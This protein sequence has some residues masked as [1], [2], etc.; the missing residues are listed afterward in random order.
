MNAN[1]TST[2]SREEL[3]REFGASGYTFFN[4][5]IEA[6]EFNSKL[7]GTDGAA[8]YD[9]MRRTDGQ[10]R[11]TLLVQ[12]L[13]IHAATWTVEAESD[14]IERDLNE[15]LFER[16]DFDEYLR[17]YLTVLDFG[18]S[19]LEK[20][21]M[22]DA[23]RLWFRKLAFRAQTSIVKWIV[24]DQTG[25]LKEIVQ[26]VSKDN[27]TRDVTIPAEKLLKITIQQEGN[28]FEGISILRSAYKHW[29]IKDQVERIDAIAQE[30]W[31]LGIPYAQGPEGG[32]DEKDERNAINTLKNL[33]SGAKAWMFFPY[34]WDF[35]VKG[36]GQGSRYDPMP[37]IKYHDELIS[38]NALAMFLNLGTTETGSRALG[39][40]FSDMFFNAEK[41]IANGIVGATNKQVIR[42]FLRVNYAN[43]DKIKATLRWSDLQIRSLETLARATSLFAAAGFMTPDRETEN[44]IRDMADLPSKDLTEDSGETG[45]ESFRERRRRNRVRRLAEPVFWR[46]LTEV[47]KSMSLR[48]IDGRQDD[49]EDQVADLFVKIRPVWVDSLIE[50]IREALSDGDASDVDQVSIPVPLRNQM[51]AGIVAIERELFRFGRQKVQEEQTRQLRQ[52]GADEALQAA[53]AR[54]FRDEPPES[55]EI[56]DVFWVRARRYLNRLSSRVE[57]VAI[58]RALDLH[59]TKGTDIDPEDLDTLSDDLNGMWMNTARLEAKAVISSAFNMGRTHQAEIQKEEI[60]FAEYSAILDENLCE[61]CEDLDG[62]RFD[63]GSEEYY[64]NAPPNKQ[65]LSAQSGSNRCRCVYAFAFK[66]EQRSRG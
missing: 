28:N 9:K 21:W 38:R 23:S 13:P 12:K 7:T 37:T 4:G 43:G 58:E 60:E 52:A 27:F 57:N 56:T 44:I 14:A 65:C 34:G 18:F 53:E 22:V 19:L 33:K 8:T 55:K 46:E 32:Y 26:R 54:S 64:A 11:A 50:Q 3:V 6:G 51:A 35:G 15:M 59:R 29:F 48:E 47:E 66:T 25:D 41:A 17:H 39:G 1:D 30:R 36:P 20:V 63:V 45:G 62:E 40:T 2:L 61:E 24:D 49:A 42:P 10:V 5:L 31:G 16:I